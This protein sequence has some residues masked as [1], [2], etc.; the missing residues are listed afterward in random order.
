MT[1]DLI[2]QKYLNLVEAIKNDK[3]DLVE[4]PIL[5]RWSWDEAPDIE[6][7][8]L[9]RGISKEESVNPEQ[10]TMVEHDEEGESYEVQMEL[11]LQHSTSIH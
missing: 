2:K 10:M 6:F 9:I 1:D 11:P 8:L 7:Q 5:F 3:H 4:Q